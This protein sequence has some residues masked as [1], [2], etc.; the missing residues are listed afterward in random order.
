M[1]LRRVLE[2]IRTN[3]DRPVTVFEMA[4][5]A[6]Q[7]ESRFHRA[8]RLSFGITVH[9]YLMSRRV[10]MAKQLMLNTAE[11]LRRSAATC[12]MC[13]QSHLTRWVTRMTGESPN[14]WRRARTQGA[15][16]HDVVGVSPLRSAF[17]V[18]PQWAV[19]RRISSGH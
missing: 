10:D 18:G 8:F 15:F 13:D 16:D 19:T 11:P 9:Q 14:R 4:A 3:L 12:G 6:G 7:S 5:I 2:F 1:Q 17:P